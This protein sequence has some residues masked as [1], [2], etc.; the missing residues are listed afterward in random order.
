MKIDFITQ[1]SGVFDSA[2]MKEK[3]A[4]YTLFLLTKPPKR[5]TPS[6]EK[7]AS[8]S[9]ETLALDKSTQPELLNQQNE[10]TILKT[11]VAFEIGQNVQPINGYYECPLCHNKVTSQGGIKGLIRHLLIYTNEK[12]FKCETY[13]KS[14]TQYSN[15]K[16]HTL[17]HT[18]P[19]ECPICKKKFSCR[20]ELERH[21]ALRKKITGLKKLSIFNLINPTEKDDRTRK[22]PSQAEKP[23]KC[24]HPGCDYTTKRSFDLETH[25]R[26]H[27]NKRPYI[28][29]ICKKNIYN[30][31]KSVSA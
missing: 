29:S 16:R 19:F 11:T 20:E 28:C 4:A 22:I 7:T 1:K 9:E 6:P 17:S 3:Y 13:K 10:I 25:M 2:Q 8:I 12:P 14:F 30:F 26:T 15:L 23:W 31:I 21:K 5:K 18:K 27:T 24:T